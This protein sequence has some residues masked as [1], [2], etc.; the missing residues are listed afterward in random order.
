MG[1]EKRDLVAHICDAMAVENPRRSDFRVVV[2]EHN[3]LKLV[4]E[5]SVFDRGAYVPVPLIE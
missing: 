2:T 1:D 3:A 4:G 5:G